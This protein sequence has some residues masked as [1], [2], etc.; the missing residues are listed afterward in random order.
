MSLKRSYVTLYY[1]TLITASCWAG[2]LK[3]LF[4]G[5][6]ELELNGLGVI[7]ESAMILAK[8]VETFP[9]RQM[10]VAIIGFIMVSQGLFFLTK[11]LTN[12]ICGDSYRPD[13]KRVGRTNG[14]F[15]CL[16]GLAL[17]AGGTSAALY[18]STIVQYIFGV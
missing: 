16:I 10:A 13:G 3:A 17:S 7:K 8:S 4:G 14:F 9:T 6:T 12:F 11:G 18:C 1:S 15:Q 2:S 5:K